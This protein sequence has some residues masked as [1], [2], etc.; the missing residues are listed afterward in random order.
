MTEE[1][2]TEEKQLKEACRQSSARWA[3][4]IYHHEGEWGILLHHALNK[5]RQKALSEYIRQPQI[6]SWMAGSLSSAHSRSRSSQAYAPLDCQRVYLFPNMESRQLLI[7][8]ANQLSKNAENLFRILSISAPI[9]AQTNER[10]RQP[11]AAKGRAVWNEWSTVQPE[12]LQKPQLALEGILEYLGSNILPANQSAASRRTSK[13]AGA[14][15]A[16]LAIRSGE[17][18]RIQATWQCSA[19]LQGW[20]LQISDNEA[21]SSITTSRLGCILEKNPSFPSPVVFQDDPGRHYSYLPAADEYEAWM[22]IPILIGQHVIGIAA[23]LSNSPGYLSPALM[24][25]AT[26]LVNRVAYM[27]ENAILFSEAARYLQQL[28][29]LNE[30]ATTASSVTDIDEVSRRVMKRLRRVFD[31]DWAALF[32][33]SADGQSMREYGGSEYRNPRPLATGTPLGQA[34]ATGL[35]VMV[36]DLSAHSDQDASA[37]HSG[38]E[39]SGAEHSGAE[40]SGAGYSGAGGTSTPDTSSA[41]TNSPILPGAGRPVGAASGSALSVPLKYQGKIIGAMDLM[42]AKRNAFTNQDEQLL[43]LIAS[44]LAGLFENMRLNRETQE[45]AITLQNTVRQLQAVRE[46]ALDITADLDLNTLLTR[47]V[48][49]AR[50]LVEARGAELGLAEGTEFAPSGGAKTSSISAQVGGFSNQEDGR[51]A[52]LSS[53]PSQPGVRVVVSATPWDD[54]T[55]EVKRSSQYDWG[56][57]K[58]DLTQPESLDLEAHKS[59]L[60]AAFKEPLVIN[61]YNTWLGRLKPEG[62]GARALGTAPIAE[63][64]TAGLRNAAPFRTAAGVPLRLRGEVIGTLTVM[65]DRPDKTFHEED[66]QI[67]ELLAPQAAISIRNARLYQELQE[68]IKAQRLAESRLVRSARLAAVGEMAAGIAHELNNP[69]TTVTGFVELVLNDLPSDAKER[70]DL[71]LVLE[72]ALRARGVVRRLLDFARQSEPQWIR[73]DINELI[74]QA[75][76]LVSHLIRI[77]KITLRFEFWHDLPWIYVDPNQI[78]QVLLNL[79][80]N[81]ILAMP[82]GGDLSIQTGVE[83]RESSES[84]A[85]ANKD[86]V[87][88][89]VKDSGTGISSENMERIFEPFFTTRPDNKGTGLGLSVSYGIVTSHGGTLEVESTPDEGSCFTIYLPLEAK[90]DEDGS[91]LI[92]PE[93]GLMNVH[94]AG[95]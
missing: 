25:D 83:K 64:G 91:G 48:Q 85:T 35:P 71:E 14:N 94:S 30:L 70:A 9:T 39:H 57:D 82:H 61:D 16:Y 80:H 17:V 29:L 73:T 46:T 21:L 19:K 1:L 67:L 72:E 27:V 56:D 10:S 68:R 54:S 55:N 2:L 43:I 33:L 76:T 49:R 60:M 62:E 89:A 26:Q 11:Q 66:V 41:G 40:H 95:S 22:G 75:S 15:A 53:R 8:G 31:T 86:W 34:I 51:Q 4:W 87:F 59:P 92:K 50:H 38:A 36:N 90:L 7:V 52:H 42:S 69:L 45:R 78:K 12:S 88:I 81:A 13:E 32:L 5:R 63:P 79:M 23:F 84:N 6:A 37:E 20:E 18:F 77:N 24:Q 93:G 47:I 74:S 58:H 3:A 44:H 28:A 65:D